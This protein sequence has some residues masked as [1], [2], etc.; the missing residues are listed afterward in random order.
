MFWVRTSVLSR[1]VGL[2]LKWSD[3][4]SEPLPVDGTMLHAIER[5]FGI[6]PGAMGMACAVTNVRGVTR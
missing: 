3:Y 2:D 1:F 6:A 4:P 5:L